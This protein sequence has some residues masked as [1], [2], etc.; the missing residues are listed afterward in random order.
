M[1]LLRHA[2]PGSYVTARRV[3]Y[4]FILLQPACRESLQPG[5]EGQPRPVDEVAGDPA[6]LPGA[7]QHDSWFEDV[8]A[9]TG[10][11]ST[12]RNGREGE[13]YSL[14]ETVGGGVGMFDFDC[15]DDLDL[16]FTG[17]GRI[18]V[19]AG[20]VSG[21]PGSL[22]QNQANWRFRDVSGA[23]LPT[24]VPDYSHGCSVSDFDADGWPD[25]LVTCFGTCR[26]LRNAGDGTFTDVTQSAALDVPGWHTASA[27]AD[28]DLDGLVDL[29][30]AGYCEWSLDSKH[31]WCGDHG[32]GIQDVCPP[33]RYA[34]S[35]DRLFHN[36]GDGAFDDH[37]AVVMIRADGRGLGVV[38]CDVNRDGWPDFYV[39][40]DGDAN[41]LYLGR[42][43]LPMTEA[44]F[45][46]GV[47]FDANGVAQGGM[48]VD[49]SDFDRDGD[50]DLWVTN[51]EL[52]DNALY[53]NS[54]SS[55]FSYATLNGGLGGQ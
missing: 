40:N 11:D 34:P 7:I 4:V 46:L 26:L 39:V 37:T 42:A 29:Y 54:D 21:L 10:V 47:A 15:D 41:H 22:Y 14:L 6:V 36:R 23:S 3:A 25:L 19:D 55:L 52:Q 16:Y 8:T 30:V 17:G 31:D 35:T 38:S 13:A 48:G 20:P 53:E 51:F 28:Y 1:G 12:Y 49:Q 2:N 27:W 32:R 44:G 9:K 33:Q 45:E 5:G 43:D 24:D 18:A 50:F